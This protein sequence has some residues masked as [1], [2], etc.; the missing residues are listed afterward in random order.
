MM[1]RRHVS[2]PQV[3][4]I[5]TTGLLTYAC[6]TRGQTQEFANEPGW[7]WIVHPIAVQSSGRP[8]MYVAKH[9]TDVEAADTGWKGFIAIMEE[10]KA[11]ELM[12][13]FARQRTYH[14]Y[15]DWRPIAFDVDGNR[16]QLRP[17]VAAG[18][19]NVMLER[20]SSDLATL[21]FSRVAHVGLE[22]LTLEGFTK[23]SKVAAELATEQGL[24]VLPFPVVGK[25]YPFELT[26]INGDV[27]TSSD[28]RGKVV[29]LDFW[30]TWCLPCMKKMPEL[31]ELYATYHRDGFEIV[32]LNFD[33]DTL[34]CHNAIRALDLTWP[35]MTVPTEESQRQLW[36]RAMGLQ[37][38]GRLLVID[39]DGVLRADCTPAELRSYITMLMEGERPHRM[40]RKR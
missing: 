29:V 34:T 5:L 22:G 33:R 11:Q 9:Q 28:L 16:H 17:Q 14:D 31:K 40:K 21:P 27:L 13:V 7:A 38:L 25:P 8:E 1:F 18:T 26:G 23:E 39:R 3:L 36:M 2:P 6:T 20:W 37:T 10:G 12:L 19:G 32:G 35:Q 30:A 15:Y 24:R 4:V